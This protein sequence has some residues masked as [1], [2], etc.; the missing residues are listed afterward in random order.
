MNGFNQLTRHESGRNPPGPTRGTKSQ[1]RLR[2]VNDAEGPG[3]APPAPVAKSRSMSVHHQHNVIRFAAVDVVLVRQG[4]AESR[5]ETG[6][7]ATWQNP[8]PKPA[9]TNGFMI[10][11]EN[12][13]E[14]R[15][16]PRQIPQPI[17][18]MFVHRTRAIPTLALGACAAAVCAL[19]HVTQRRAFGSGWSPLV[20]IA[21][22]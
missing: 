5:S 2:H 17:E 4:L 9:P 13:S 8:Y 12:V 1:A 20:V 6:S 22:T 15:K 3:G 18:L 21:R 7:P 19:P 11:F 14:R 10:S 16:L